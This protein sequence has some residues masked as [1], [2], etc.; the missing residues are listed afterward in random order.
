MS[1]EAG[2]FHALRFQ[3]RERNFSF[4]FLDVMTSIVT[5]TFSFVDYTTRLLECHRVPETMTKKVGHARENCHKL[6]F[7]FRVLFFLKSYQYVRG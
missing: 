7:R 5:C 6:S 2:D 4:G 1:Q 3:S